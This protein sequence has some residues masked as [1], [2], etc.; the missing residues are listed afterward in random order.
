[1]KRVLLLPLLAGLFMFSA[2]T[3]G[4]SSG[5][6]PSPAQAGQGRGCGTAAPDP[7]R[8]AE[9]ENSFQKFQQARGGRRNG[10]SVVIPVY[11]HVINKGPG[12]ENGDVPDHMLRAQLRVLNDS[13]SGA[14]GGAATPFR[15]ELAGIDRTTNA[16]WFQMGIL[17]I[18]ER[19][20]KAALRR[21][22]AGALNVYTTDGGG[23]LGWATFPSNYHS[24]PT[25]DGVV[26][27]YSS[28]PGGSLY[29][30]NEG[31]TA[32]HEVGHWL[33]LYHT[34]QNGCTPDNDYVEDTP[35]EA[36]PAFGCPAG[37][38]TCT[39]SRYPGLD[40]V[41]NFMDYT[42]DPCMFQFTAGQSA[43]MEGK[44]AQFRKP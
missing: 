34:F 28:L 18:Q 39:R 9:L 27:L 41:F 33:G 42:D 15:F 4:D 22:G 7:A 20:A 6:T 24:Q 17:S 25:Q 37:R 16:D 35:A 13:F 19:Q 43:R 1:M 29:P 3:R 32:T 30:Y 2:A 23:Y 14:T 40:P 8:M 36:A 10:G 21:G 11:F 31:D 38:D 12:I 26:L 5:P 44:Y